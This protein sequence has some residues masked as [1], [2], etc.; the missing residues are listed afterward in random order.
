MMMPYG[1]F[2]DGK[3]I[4]VMGNKE[5][6]RVCVPYGT[7]SFRVGE[8]DDLQITVTPEQPAAYIKATMK[9]GAWKSKIQIQPATASE[10][11]ESSYPHVLPYSSA[12]A[13][14]YVVNTSAVNE[15]RISVTPV[16]PNGSICYCAKCGNQMST[17]DRFCAK[18]GTPTGR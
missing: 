5:N 17:S 18:C 12:P 2:V 16:Q 7:H 10:I 15:Q 9:V 13:D 4:G 8:S 6:L 1:V 14:N 11:P 3:Q